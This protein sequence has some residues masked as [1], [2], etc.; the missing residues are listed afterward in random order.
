MASVPPITVSAAS[1]V[2]CLPKSSYPRESIESGALLVGAR[3]KVF[4]ETKG[5]NW[6]VTVKPVKKTSK[7]E[8]LGVAGALLNE[9]LSHAFRQKV[10]ALNRPL[11]SPVLERALEAGLPQTPHD[12]LEQLEP[13][14]R[15]DRE[16]DIA[17]LMEAAKRWR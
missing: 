16:K 15:A 13:Q 10:V 6:I 9:A 7:D 4:L 17:D 5:S 14:V 1:V 12:P 2:A 8:L 3:A 11:A